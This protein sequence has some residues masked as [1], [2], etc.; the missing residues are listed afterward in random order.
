VLALVL[1]MFSGIVWMPPALA[2]HRGDAPEWGLAMRMYGDEKARRV[3]D[4]VTVIV[5]EASSVSKEA[6]SASAKS[7]SGS[8]SASL[9]PPYMMVQGTQRP[10]A[11][12]EVGLGAWNWGMDNAFKGGGSINN[13]DEFTSTLTA[14]VTDVLPNGNLMLEGKRTVQLQDETIQMVLTGTVR[15]RDIQSD[16]SV[17]SSRIADATIRYEPKGPLSREQKRGLLTRLFN[18]VNLF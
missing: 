1:G 3:G 15:P 18:W 13:E 16:N 11:W 6:S 9:K 10:S 17:E 7:T 5:K 4:L 8:G 14:R 12:S 2:S